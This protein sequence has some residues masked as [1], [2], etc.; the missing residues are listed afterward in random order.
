MQIFVDW[1]IIVVCFYGM[2]DN[3]MFAMSW[4]EDIL[5]LP[6]DFFYH[7][8]CAAFGKEGSDRIL[9]K[10]SEK[11]RVLYLGW[12]LFGTWLGCPLSQP[13][14]LVIKFPQESQ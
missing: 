13:S 2:M 12:N 3:I 1:I 5:F 7:A 4:M 11:F 8:I 10:L 6:F 9:M 14:Y